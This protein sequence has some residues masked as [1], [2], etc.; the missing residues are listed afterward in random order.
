[1]AV[2]QD[3]LQ[4]NNLLAE[5]NRGW[6]AAKG[7][8]ALNLVSSPGSRKPSMSKLT[9][10]YVVGMDHEYARRVLEAGG[11]QSLLAKL[12]ESYRGYARR[13]GR[14]LPWIGRLGEERSPVA[15]R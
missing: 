4:Q 5:R 1:M 3:V 15:G 8:L 10:C 9:C 6:F 7:I 14:F 2:E 12:G 11:S 13:V